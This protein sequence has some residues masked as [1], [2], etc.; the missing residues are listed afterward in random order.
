MHFYISSLPFY[1]FPYT[2]GYLLS[3]GLYAMAREGG[4]GEFPD[5]YRRF[6]LATGDRCTEEAV[7]DSFGHDLQQPEFW[8]RS[9]DVVAQRVASFE[10]LAAQ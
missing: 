1:N 6:L 10:E 5:Q 9:L 4:G 8:N 3:L 7:A 2:F